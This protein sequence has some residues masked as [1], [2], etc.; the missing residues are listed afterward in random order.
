MTRRKL[1]SRPAVP[2]RP[3]RPPWTRDSTLLD[4]CTGCGGCVAACPE[5]IVALDAERRPVIE[6]RGGECTFCARCADACPAPVFVHRSEAPFPHVAGIGPACLAARGVVCQ[7][8]GDHCP[9]AAISFRPRL[10]APPLPAIAERQCSGCGACIAACPAGA[11]APA[12][13]SS[14]QHHV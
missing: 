9:N 10:G 1:L 4:A 12:A 3:V 5:R 8:C 7:S 6:L 2:R 11:I 14:G 13:R